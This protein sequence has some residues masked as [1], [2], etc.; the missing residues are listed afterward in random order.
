MDYMEGG[1][2]VVAL[3]FGARRH[4]RRACPV[5]TEEED[6]EREELGSAQLC[7]SRFAF[8]LFQNKR[9]NKKE[10]E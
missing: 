9:R 5:R 4:V 8:F 6:K 7:F 2:A 3:S 10:E 1:G